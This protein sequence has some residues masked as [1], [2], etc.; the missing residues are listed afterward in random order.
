MASSHNISSPLGNPLGLAFYWQR[1]RPAADLA[2]KKA[3]P[4]FFL[5]PKKSGESRSKN[6]KN[7]ETTQS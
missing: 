5:C 1:L 4:R 2:G 7:E 6:K 3:V